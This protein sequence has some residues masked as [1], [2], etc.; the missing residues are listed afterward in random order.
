MIRDVPYAGIVQLVV[1][2]NLQFEFSLTD[3]ANL[4][5]QQL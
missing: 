1:Y 3:A 5:Q 4:G 2:R